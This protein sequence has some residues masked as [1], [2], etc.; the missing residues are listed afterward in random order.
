M[1]DRQLLVEIHQMLKR[2]CSYI[3]KLESPE[4]KQ[5]DYNMQFM[6]N[7]AAD[8]YVETLEKLRNGEYN[9]TTPSKDR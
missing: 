6:L 5:E 2:V 7:V 4:H 8:M 1:D 3:D 9:N